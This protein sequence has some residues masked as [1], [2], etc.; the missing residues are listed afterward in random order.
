MR[1]LTLASVLLLGLTGG[2]SAA[3][4]ASPETI[5]F[6]G[7]TLVLAYRA[8]DATDGIRE[9]IPK[10]ET[11]E[12]WTKLAATREYGDLDDPAAMAGAVVKDLKKQYP[13]SPFKI[14]ENK[15]TG[16]VIV[17]FVLWPDDGSL[18]EFNVFR[19][20]KNP[21]GGLFSQQYALRAYGDDT[22][23]FL[24]DLRP[25]RERLVGTMAGIG[26]A[27]GGVGIIGGVVD[28]GSVASATTNGTESTEGWNEVTESPSA[29]AD[30]G[31]SDE[32]DS[33][34]DDS[35]EDDSDEDD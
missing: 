33:D 31:D 17:D 11:L 18:A 9:F 3:D 20:S 35:N 23:G 19:Y 22:E 29:T 15:Q 14:M 28:D 12:H 1:S 16:E 24:R 34:E 6:D 10:G 5:D 7:E 32:G 2:G 21:E 13:Q 4:P 30:E 26:L 27:H 8:A 25:V